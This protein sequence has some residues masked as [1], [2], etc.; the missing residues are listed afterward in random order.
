MKEKVSCKEVMRYVCECLAQ[1]TSSDRCLELKEHLENCE[2]CRE[3]FKSVELTIDC[4]RKYN[5]ELPKNVHAKLMNFLNLN[6]E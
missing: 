2:N 5:V 3:Y 1:D 4:Y 6:D